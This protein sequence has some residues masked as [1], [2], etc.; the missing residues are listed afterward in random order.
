[1][2]DVTGKPWTRRR[3]TARSRVDLGPRVA[4]AVGEAGGGDSTTGGIG[5]AEVLGTARLAGI[6]AAKQTSAL[7]PLCHPLTVSNVDVHLTLV[8]DSVHVEGRAE[9]VGPTG[10]EMEALAACAVASLSVR[11]DGPP[12]RPGGL[13]HRGRPLEEDGWPLGDVVAPDHAMTSAE[14]AVRL[15]Q[16]RPVLDGRE[17]ETA[18]VY[19]RGCDLPELLPAGARGTAVGGVTAPAH[20]GGGSAWATP[21]SM[22]Q[23]RRQRRRANFHRPS[24]RVTVST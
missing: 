20:S 24:R 11:G 12:D 13:D 4:Q 14:L 2:V 7:I 18:L 5:W 21:L 16:A 22:I 3:A 15:A 17:I 19:E 1:M 10:V 8:G 9:V 23:A 6:Q